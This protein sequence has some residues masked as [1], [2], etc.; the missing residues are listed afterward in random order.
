MTLICPETMKTYE[1]DVNIAA[2]QEKDLWV[3][4][5]NELGTSRIAVTKNDI[6]KNYDVGF[7]TQTL[8]IH[9]DDFTNE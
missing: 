1:E 8:K 3:H 2:G 7:G 6:R 4:F 9:E 5:D